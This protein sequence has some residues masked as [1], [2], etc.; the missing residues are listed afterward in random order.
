MFELLPPSGK[1][2]EQAHPNTVPQ[3]KNIA[4]YTVDK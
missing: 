4:D 2:K 3:G 1:T